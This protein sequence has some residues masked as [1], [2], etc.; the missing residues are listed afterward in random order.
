MISVQTD[1]LVDDYLRHLQ[2]AAAH[3]PRARRA[4]LLAEI[5]EHIDAALRQQETVDETA[6]RNVLERLGPPE[7]I[8]AAAEP[9][10]AEPARVGRLE[11]GA[12]IALLVPFV[13]W[14]VGAVLVLL[15]RAWSL[16]EKLVGLVLLFLPVVLMG[17]SLT[18]VGP[19]RPVEGAAPGDDRSV[20]V[21]VDEG[22]A[23][24]GDLGAIELVVILGNGLPSALF[25]AWRLR[26]D[27]R[28]A[29]KA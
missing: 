11:F 24:A 20:A 26:T 29:M 1:R 8:V 16:R 12:L 21:A 7:E 9:A 5:R 15:S 18:Q 25:L 23:P 10:P 14:L 19:S 27:R 2:N 17:L 6:V 22:E 4:E 3:L 13:G 28:P